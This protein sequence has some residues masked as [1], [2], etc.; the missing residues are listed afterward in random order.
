MLQLYDQKPISI[1]M[2]D[3]EYRIRVQFC[4]VKMRMKICQIRHFHNYLSRLSRHIDENTETV[5]L[6]LVKDNLNISISLN[7]FLQ[8]SHAVKVVMAEKFGQKS[9][10]LN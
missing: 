10:I 2:V 1:F 6:L 7:H 5:E 4:N 8:L 9:T 3:D